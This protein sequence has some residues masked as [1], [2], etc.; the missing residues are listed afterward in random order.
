MMTVRCTKGSV[1]PHLVKTILLYQN[2][3]ADWSKNEWFEQ[4][5]R[6]NR[7]KKQTLTQKKIVIVYSKDLNWRIREQSR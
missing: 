4:G 6:C 5:K 2:M 3:E 7:Y 1:C